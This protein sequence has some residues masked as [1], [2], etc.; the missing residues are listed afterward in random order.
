MR[1]AGQKYF[2]Y[3][4]VTVSKFEI[5]FD[6]KPTANELALQVASIS[7]RFFG[8][9]LVQPHKTRHHDV[10]AESARIKA[11]SSSADG[12]RVSADTSSSISHS[13]D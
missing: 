12:I 2:P 4:L 13:N 6:G 7:I 9:P 5:T 1:V 3:H 10:V 8:C 11:E